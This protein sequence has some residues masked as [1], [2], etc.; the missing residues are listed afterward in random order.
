MLLSEYDI[1]YITHKAIK[2]RA[3]AEH[4]ACHPI[5]IYQPMRPKFPDEDILSLLSGD[6]GDSD[7]NAWV[8][9]F[10]GASN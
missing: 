2:S 4:L 1:V 9:F 3:L 7:N 6:G 5:P 8:M 10:D